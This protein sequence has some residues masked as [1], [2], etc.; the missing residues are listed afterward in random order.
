MDALQSDITAGAIHNAAEAN[1]ELGVLQMLVPV[2]NASAG[3]FFL[4][5]LYDQLDARIKE[6]DNAHP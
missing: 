5:P 2:T 6:I 3:A 1:G 4:G